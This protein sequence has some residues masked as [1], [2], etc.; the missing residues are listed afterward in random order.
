M[1]RMLTVLARCHA[2]RIYGKTLAKAAA[3]LSETPGLETVKIFAKVPY[4]QPTVTLDV[5]T[6]RVRVWIGW[7]IMV[8]EAI[9]VLWIG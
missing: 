1:F 7:R 9:V 5:W 2:L 4:L 6:R 3:S 8:V